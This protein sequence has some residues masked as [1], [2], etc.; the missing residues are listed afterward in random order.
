MLRHV[1]CLI[2]RNATRSGW[3]DLQVAV[4]G[5]LYGK[6]LFLLAFPQERRMQQGCNSLV[7]NIVWGSGRIAYAIR[8]DPHTLRPCSRRGFDGCAVGSNDR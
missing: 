6:M 3:W 5:C 7:R 1:K 8:P 4:C 2:G